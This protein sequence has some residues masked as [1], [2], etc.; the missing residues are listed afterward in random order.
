VSETVSEHGRLY[1]NLTGHTFKGFQT[2]K[3][4]PI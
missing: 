2:L 4:L 1:M 3:S